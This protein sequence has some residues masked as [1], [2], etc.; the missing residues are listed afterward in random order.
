MICLAQ[1]G[2]YRNSFSRIFGKNFVKVTLLL[3][4]L[5]T[6]W[7]DETFLL[8]ENFS[9][10]HTVRRTHLKI[11]SNWC[12]IK[13]QLVSRNFCSKLFHEKISSENYK[14]KVMLDSTLNSYQVSW[15]LEIFYQHFSWVFQYFSIGVYTIIYIFVNINWPCSYLILHEYLV[16]RYN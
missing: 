16:C 2:I 14:S 9:F 6:S 8:R 1:C 4:K 12:T 7:I 11:S 13:L 10:F 15:C 3:K 5:L